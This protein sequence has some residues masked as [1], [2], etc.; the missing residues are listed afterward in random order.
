MLVSGC[1]PAGVARRRIRDDG[2]TLMESIVAAVILLLIAVGVISALI[3]TGGWYARATIRTQAASVASEVLAEIR[4]R[5]YDALQVVQGGAW[6]AAIPTTMTVDTI[7][8]YYSVETSMEAVVDTLTIAPMK[9]IT[10][11]VDSLRQPMAT[12]VV[13]VAYVSGWSRI[14]PSSPQFDVPVTVHCIDYDTTSSSQHLGGVRVEL[15][16]VNNLSL[17]RYYAVTGADGIAH[18]PSVAEDQYWLT[19]DPTNPDVH[20]KYFPRRVYPAHGGSVSNPILADNLYNLAVVERTGNADSRATLRVG[21]FRDGGWPSVS[22]VPV[23]GLRIH[24]QAILNYDAVLN[25]DAGSSDY[26]GTGTNAD[27]TR[28]T[29]YPLPTNDPQQLTYSALTNAYG[30]AMI[31]VPWTLEPTGQKW[32]VWYTTDAESRD[33]LTDYPGSW[34]SWDKISQKKIN[35]PEMEPGKDVL[36]FQYVIGQPTAAP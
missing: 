3:A 20:A 26:F 22:P 17:V 28:Q 7:N 27:G 12:P 34:I 32:H 2:F 18:F 23:V 13:A 11:T 15:R 16:D 33:K 6:P 14:D 25:P 5:N 35:E 19:S 1:A 9:R 36:Q 29:R 4:S 30:I 24:A 8:G 10:V 31:Q 21:A